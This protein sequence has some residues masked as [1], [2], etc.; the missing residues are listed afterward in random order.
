MVKTLSYQ[1][2]IDKLNIWKNSAPVLHKKPKWSWLCIENDKK[3]ILWNCDRNSIKF[4]KKALTPLWRRG[5]SFD[6]CAT[7]C[8]DNR[9]LPQ[10][11]STFDQFVVFSTLLCVLSSIRLFSDLKK[12]ERLSV[13]FLAWLISVYIL[14]VKVE[15]LLNEEVPHSLVVNTMIGR[16]LILTWHYKLKSILKA[17]ALIVVLHLRAAA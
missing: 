17:S 3:E 16:W 8:T 11:C 2:R 14:S 9:K 6:F 12:D 15:W 1:L 10:F 7:S 4:F 5:K 13:N